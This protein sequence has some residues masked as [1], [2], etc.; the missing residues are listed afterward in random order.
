MQIEMDTDRVHPRIESGRVES[1]VRFKAMVCSCP[2]GYRQ[3]KGRYVV[4][5]PK[6]FALMK[7]KF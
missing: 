2:T 3:A 6:E 4:S 7:T 1:R 5:I